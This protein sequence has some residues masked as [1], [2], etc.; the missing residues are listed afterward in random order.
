MTPIQGENHADP[1]DLAS[2]LEMQATQS[3]IA[4]VQ[5]Q[6]KRSQEPDGNGEY[7][8]LECIT[9]DNEIGEGRL[10]HSIKNTLCVFCATRLEKSR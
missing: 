8:I 4:Q 1:S 10:K 6:L 5:K 3:A 9:C 7:H 2:D